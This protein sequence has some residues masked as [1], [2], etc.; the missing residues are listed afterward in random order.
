[1]S[2]E[3]ADVARKAREGMVTGD[4]RPMAKWLRMQGDF[5]AQLLAEAIERGVLTY[6]LPHKER[7]YL[8]WMLC[9][10]FVVKQLE[11][12]AKLQDALEDAQ[13]KFGMSA[14]NVDRAKARWLKKGQDELLALRYLTGPLAKSPTPP[15]VKKNGGDAE[16]Q[17]D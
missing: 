12:G 17:P 11:D 13:E 5:N 8:K 2:E 16:R 4:I 14:R 3:N 7:V 6:K 15:K 10:Q 9:G 1:M